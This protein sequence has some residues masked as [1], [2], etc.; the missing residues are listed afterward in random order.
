M[1]RSKK[2]GS[3]FGRMDR[4]GAS[5]PRHPEHIVGGSASRE[6][7]EKE[8][9]GLINQ[10]DDDFAVSELVKKGQA[11]VPAVLG[12][13][14][15]GKG[16]VRYHASLVLAQIARDLA[17]PKLFKDLATP[18]PKLFTAIP[19]LIEALRDSDVKVRQ[20]VVEALGRIGTDEAVPA[21]IDA[22]RNGDAVIRRNVVEALGSIGSDK[23]LPG[24]DRGPA[25]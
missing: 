11:A 7:L 21:L 16:V 24:I 25:G 18:T 22:L 14:C 4:V 20:N 12:A 1:A 19:A 23:A 13:L 8:I 17:T 10:L 15:G 6:E 5:P 9:Q 3:V 2:S